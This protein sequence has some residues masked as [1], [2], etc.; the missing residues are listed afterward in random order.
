MLLT[1]DAIDAIDD[2]LQ[3]LMD[4]FRKANQK[5][6]RPEARA[7][8]RRGRAEWDGLLGMLAVKPKR[9]TKLQRCKV[10][11]AGLLGTVPRAMSSIRRANK[12]ENYYFHE[13]MI[14]RALKEMGAVRVQVGYRKRKRW[15][16]GLPKKLAEMLS[17]VKKLSTVKPTTQP[18]K[19][20]PTPAKPGTEERI[21]EYARRAA[22]GLPVATRDD[23]DLAEGDG[24][25]MVLSEGN[26]KDM[27]RR[28]KEK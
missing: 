9:Q 22:A 23:A 21:A 8:A 24:L 13:R 10:W 17:T 4:E 11:L 16:I 28:L 18:Q 12:K 25:E 20:E 19:A 15:L 26:F 1:P 6:N 2:G 7:L 5:D 3:A 27:V 14:Q